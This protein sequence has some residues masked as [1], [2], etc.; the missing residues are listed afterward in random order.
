[1]SPQS[2]SVL[3][4]VYRHDPQQYTMIHMNMGREVSRRLREADQ[5][6]LRALVETG[7]FEGERIVHAI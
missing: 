3:Q 7:L 4:Q 1:M 5:R 2:A 6:L